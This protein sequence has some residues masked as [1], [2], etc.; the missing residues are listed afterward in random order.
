MYLGQSFLVLKDSFNSTW[1][2]IHKDYMISHVK[3]KGLTCQ[4]VWLLWKCCAFFIFSCIALIFGMVSWINSNPKFLYA[5]LLPNTKAYIISF[6]TTLHRV[7]SQYWCGNHCCK[8]IQLMVGDGSNF[9]PPLTYKPLTYVLL[10][11]FFVM[12]DH[13]VANGFPY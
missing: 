8:Q 11:E 9:L 10:S 3:S 1:G 12:S 7:S 13:L 2:V 6:H 4:F 5:S